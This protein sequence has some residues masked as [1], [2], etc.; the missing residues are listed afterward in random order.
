MGRGVLLFPL[1][2]LLGGCHEIYS[3]YCDER[4]ERIDCLR[5]ADAESETLLRR[6]L[7]GVEDAA[8]PYLLQ[9][10]HYEVKACNNPKANALGSDFDGYVKL[11]VFHR[12]SCYYRAQLDYKSGDWHDAL[13]RL[14]EHLEVEL[15]AP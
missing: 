6:Y 10:S 4:A 5:G 1:L 14:M 2:L 12:G 11:Q 15:L 7:P 13:P 9:V 3:Q 8:C